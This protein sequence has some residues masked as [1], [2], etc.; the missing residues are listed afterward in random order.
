MVMGPLT[1]ALIGY[2]WAVGEASTVLRAT[3]A[4]V[5]MTALVMVPLLVLIGVPAVGFSWLAGGVGE[6]VVLITCARKHAQFTILARLVPPSMVAVVAGCVGWYVSRW[7]G[8]TVIA[9]LA[10]AL[11]GVGVYVVSLWISHRGYLLD[12]IRL[13]T[14][15]LQGAIGR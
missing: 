8:D 3:I 12:S 2:L 10:G 13:S 15:G 11:T 6:A 9:G 7:A 1:V 5:V 14:R 4:G